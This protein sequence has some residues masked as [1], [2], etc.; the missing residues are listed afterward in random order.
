[1]SYSFN[2]VDCKW[3]PCIHGD[4]RVEMYS[5]RETLVKSHQIHGLQGETPLETA[6]IYRLLLAVLHSA[7]RGPKDSSEWNDLWQQG[8]GDWNL[9]WLLDYLKAWYQHFDLFHPDRPFFQV[10]DDRVKPKSVLDI[11][12]GMG[13]ANELFDH[14]SVTYDVALSPAQAAR[15]LIVGQLFGLGGGCDPSQNLYL[16]S[17]T[18]AK[19]VIFLLEGKNLFQTLALNLL[20]YNPELN[21]PIGGLGEDFP[22]WEMEDPYS[23]TRKL[24][25]GYLDYLTWHNRRLYLIPEQDEN[26]ELVVRKMM[27]APGL[28]MDSEVLHPMKHYKAG[29]KGWY[30]EEFSEDKSLWRES[31]TLFLLNET[32]ADKSH[33]PPLIF[34]W[35]SFLIDRGYIEASQIY[36]YMAL[37]MATHRTQAKIYFYREEHMPLPLRYLVDEDLVG[38]L[39]ESVNISESVRKGLWRATNVLAQILISPSLDESG[40]KSPDNKDVEN[41]LNHWNTERYYWQQLEIPFLN[42]LQELPRH[43]AAILTWR[44]TVRRAAWDALEQAAAAAGTD[45]AALKAAVRA[46]AML[47]SSLKELFPD[48]KEEIPA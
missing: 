4:G 38:K 19:G 1:M 22:A 8:K 6:A 21:R 15:R 14:V 35:L 25:Y 10:K 27:L 48:T 44:E 33:R 46:R 5:L 26:G 24:P 12:H 39:A 45:A 17:G 29:K 23:P 18:W 11:T 3:I 37:G 42:F 40:K 28:A 2:L 16:S 34:S 13:T 9:P 7:L 36:H 32:I 31:H 30:Q 43:S 41:L 47:G 20:N